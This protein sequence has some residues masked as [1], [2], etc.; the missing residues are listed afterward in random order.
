[1]TKPIVVT[2]E[3]TA[4][5]RDYWT[6]VGLSTAPANRGRAEAGV[7][8]AYETVKLPAPE[9][10]VWTGSP[11]GNALVSAFAMAADAHKSKTGRGVALGVVRQAVAALT[12]ELVP[13]DMALSMESWVWAAVEESV[14]GWGDEGLR[15]ALAHKD[16]EN[17]LR[18]HIRII[19]QNSAYGQHDAGWLG[20]YRY[21]YDQGLTAETERLM[22]MWEIA[23][24][25]GWWLPYEQICWISERPDTL[26]RDVERRLHAE[27]GPALRYPDGWGIYAWH[28][29]RV[30]AQVIMAPDTLTTEIIRAQTNDEVRRVMIERFGTDRFLKESNATIIDSSDFGV[31]WKCDIPGAAEPIVMV[32]LTNSTAEPDG[33]FKVYWRAVPPTTT[34]ALEAV[35]W[36]FDVPEAEYAEIETQT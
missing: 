27:D 6:A 33:S 5:Y 4:Q 8:L 30:P 15:R 13:P 22:G 34:R 36:T 7:R 25:A 3:L 31:L 17:T 19:T 23:E 2:P 11:M 21:F 9:R 24:S 32:Q 28:G 20:F 26:K 35:A 12:S 10:I 14:K 16:T 18:G 29:V 1:M